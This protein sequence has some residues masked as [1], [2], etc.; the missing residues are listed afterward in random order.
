MLNRFI[1]NSLPEKPHITQEEIFSKNYFYKN[2]EFKLNLLDTAGQSEYTPALPN[3]Y[4]IGTHGFILAFSIDDIHSFEV[5]Q[6][7][8]K[9][10][11]EG[12]GTKYI[13][14]ILVGNKSDLDS[15]REV[16]NDKIKKMAQIMKCPLIECSALNG[17]PEIDRIF[18]ELLKE[19]DKEINDEYPYDMKNTKVTLNFVRKHHQSFNFILLCFMVF[20]I[21]FLFIKLFSSLDCFY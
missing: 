13:P 8:N 11:L 7:V 12:I 15:Q 4:C 1:H 9:I 3:R 14:R 2:E 19:V 17:G 16:E 18:S 20:Q 5:I 6:H 21:V 10:L